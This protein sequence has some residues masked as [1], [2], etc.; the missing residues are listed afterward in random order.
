MTTE[1]G[2]TT[3]AE[4]TQWHDDGHEI[5]VEV[6]VGLGAPLTPGSPGPAGKRQKYAS[7]EMKVHCPE[8]SFCRRWS[9]QHG[10]PH[11]CFVKSDIDAVGHWDFI[12][13]ME[14]EGLPEGWSSTFPVRIIWRD[15]G[16]DGLTWKPKLAES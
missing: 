16:E 14:T 2:V 5:A 6:C 11:H 10:A 15:Q 12:D 7:T 9:K 13:Y 8:G 4:W 3:E 1:E